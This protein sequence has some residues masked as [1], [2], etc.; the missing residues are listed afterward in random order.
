MKLIQEACPLKD[1]KID[2]NELHYVL[3][4]ASDIDFEGRTDLPPEFKL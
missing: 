4:E 3:V 2:Y 1:G